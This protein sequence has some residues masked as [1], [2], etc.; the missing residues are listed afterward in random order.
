MRATHTTPHHRYVKRIDGPFANPDGGDKLAIAVRG[1]TF[2]WDASQTATV[3]D[4]GFAAAALTA[5]D[6]SVSA[7]SLVAVVGQVGSGKST[8]LSSILGDTTLITGTVT[9]GGSVAYCAQQ[10]WIRN[11]YHHAQPPLW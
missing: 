2:A 10:A 6:L 11:R 7:G 9:I 4:D 5:V 1:G 8:L 3:A